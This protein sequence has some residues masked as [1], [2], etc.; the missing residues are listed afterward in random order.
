MI[1]RPGLTLSY[2]NYCVILEKDYIALNK[3]WETRAW[4]IMTRI[5][6]VGAHTFTFHR[7]FRFL[8]PPRHRITNLNILC[9]Y[10]SEFEE[11]THYIRAIGAIIHYFPTKF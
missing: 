3:N 6:T 7:C 11:C 9:E 8:F 5:L 2:Q 1:L 10:L 4:R